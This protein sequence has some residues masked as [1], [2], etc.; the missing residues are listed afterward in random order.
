[1]TAAVVVIVIAPFIGSFLAVVALRLPNERGIVAGRS[2]CDAC[3]KTLK[4]IELIPLVSYLVQRGRCRACDAAIDPLHIAMEGSALVV[5]V[6]AALVTSGWVLAASC[7]L[8]WT[9]LTLAAI[10]WRTGLLPD[11]LTL[12]LIPIGL[13]AAW[14]FDAGGI[15]DHVIGAAAGFVGFAALAAL[16]RW[17]RGRDGLGLGDAKLLA[18]SGAW[19]GWMALPSVILFAALLGLAFVLLRR[20]PLDA[21]SRI[22]FGPALALATWVVWLYGPLV[23]G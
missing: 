5:A 12:P 22:A 20:V 2:S 23:P 21:T 14:F 15:W 6:W 11:V 4:P 17:L 3:G 18:A 7:L 10:D 13:G 8:G 19:L 9:L 1:M 16:Y